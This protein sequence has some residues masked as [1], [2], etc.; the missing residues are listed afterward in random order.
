M[1]LVILKHAFEIHI[2]I[3]SVLGGDTEIIHPGLS[4]NRATL[5]KTVEINS[6]IS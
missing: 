5:L 3:N 2:K 6:S 1:Y 4:P